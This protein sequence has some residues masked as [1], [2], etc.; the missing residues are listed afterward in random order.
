MF[1]W[2]ESGTKKEQEYYT[3][4]LTN[5]VHQ[6]WYENGQ[7][8]IDGNYINGRIVTEQSKNNL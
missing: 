6:Q 4:G 7:N 8:K 5:L 2:Y 1:S 3:I